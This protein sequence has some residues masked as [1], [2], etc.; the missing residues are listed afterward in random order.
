MNKTSVDKE[1]M[2][3]S[4]RPEK[5]LNSQRRFNLIDCVDAIGTVSV[6][7]GGVLLTR[8][9]AEQQHLLALEG[10]PRPSDV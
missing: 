4:T 3:G 9:I 1:S 10:V 2:N 5:V 6:G 8:I 7:D